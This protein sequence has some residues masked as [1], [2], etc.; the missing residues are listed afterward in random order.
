MHVLC[1]FMPIDLH[2][3]PPPAADEVWARFR[4]TMWCICDIVSRRTSKAKH[5]RYLFP[6]CQS[7]KQHWW[8]MGF[9]TEHREICWSDAPRSMSILMLPSRCELFF[10]CLYISL[11][12]SRLLCL[13]HVPCVSWH[14]W[15]ACV[16][17]SVRA[18]STPKLLSF[19]QCKGMLTAMQLSEFTL[20]GCKH[21]E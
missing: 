2:P 9:K 11:L 15:R 13:K 5:P 4:C 10:Y 21:G 3:H 7:K 1:F 6:R 8:R 18:S 14:L 19:Q 12:L 16:R 20:N 17:A